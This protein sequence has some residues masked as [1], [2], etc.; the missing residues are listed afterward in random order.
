MFFA[1]GRAQGSHRVTQALLGQGN[2]VHV[3]F[4]HDDLVE[5]AVVLA[6]LEQAVQLLALV[7]HRGFRGVQVLGLVVAQYP[8]AEGDHPAAAVADREHHPV[9]EAVVALAGVGVLD[10][11]AGVDHHLLL[12]GVAGQVLEQVVPAR[13]G[14]AQ[15]EVAGNLARQ[16]AALEIIHGGTARRVALERLAVELGGCGK[17]RVQRRIG[18]LPWLVATPAFLAGY[19]HAGGLGQLFHG[20]GEIQVVVVHDEA[21]GVAA[22]AAAETVIELLVGADGEGGG[23]FL[24]ERAAGGVVL[25]GLFHLDARSHHV[26]DVGAVQKVVN[27][28]LGNQPG[29]GS[30]IIRL[31]SIAAV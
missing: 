7:E 18:G 23:L 11:Q 14:E 5:V 9:T 22:G 3:A 29:H 13:W 25:A 1:G 17:Q 27:E 10:Q 31:G 2:D 24:V 20:L 4:D 28:A 6:R 19:F 15:A 8:A 21:E 16:A 30:L 26:D 12:Q